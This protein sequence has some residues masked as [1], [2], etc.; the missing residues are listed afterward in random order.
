M[1]GYRQWLR[2]RRRTSAW[3]GK[4]IAPIL[5]LDQKEP[6]TQLQQ[7]LGTLIKG[8]T[9]ERVNR[10]NKRSEIK[11]FW[12]RLTGLSRGQIPTEEE[13]VM[14]EQTIRTENVKLGLRSGR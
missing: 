7:T 13:E 11:T 14:A 8:G 2:A 6:K 12:C 4:F 9:R 5:G 1:F 10:L 3:A